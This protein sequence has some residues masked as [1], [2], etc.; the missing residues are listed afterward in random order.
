M[1]IENFEINKIKYNKKKKTNFPYS[2]LINFIL[3]TI[4]NQNHIITLKIFF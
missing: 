4:L 2:T 3:N 1:R